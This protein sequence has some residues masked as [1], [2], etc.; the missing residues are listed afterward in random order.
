MREK[1]FEFIF[2]CGS[3]RVRGGAINVDD[4]KKSFYTESEFFFAQSDIDIKIKNIVTSLE[5]NTDEY[6]DSINL[7]IDSQ[8]M[9]TIGVSIS[10][11]LDGSKLKKEDIQFL[12]QD[13]K[14]QLLKNYPNQNIVHII[15]QN[16]KIDDT[17][18]NFFPDKM[19]CNL[20][21]IDVLFICIPKN[22]I[23]YY[24]RIFFNTNRF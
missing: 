7:M 5:K 4:I 10:K 8:K 9:L 3:S 16:Y 18:Y 11:K 22:I 14:Q 20:I 12:I 2:D 21:S 24:K 6:L 1:K 15:I 19:N 17:N 23:D 13:A